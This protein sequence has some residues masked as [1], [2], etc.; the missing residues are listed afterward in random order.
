MKLSR[1]KHKLHRLRQKSRQ[2]VF[3][4]AAQTPYHLTNILMRPFRKSSKHD[5]LT[6]VQNQSIEK[7]RELKNPKVL[8]IGSRVVSRI[9]RR[10]MF[11][12]A[13]TYVGFDVL[14]GEN[15]DVVGDT[16]QLSDYFPE[17]EFDIIYSISVFEHLMF[18]WKAA[19]EINKVLK[20][21]GYVLTSTHP[22]WPEHEMP[23][24]FW[25][26]PQNSFTSLFNNKTGFEI[27]QVIE[28]RAMRAFPLFTDKP[29]RRIYRNKLNG[30]VFCLAR[31][32]A[33]Y[34]REKFK[35]DMKVEDVVDT[36]YPA[37]KD[38]P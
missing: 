29:M 5:Q 11:P 32:V 9:N 14:E 4:F 24:D 36:M 25:R 33:D 17:N 1:I 28:G 2:D 34:D 3:D 22:A 15:V 13:A 37:L 30:S 7:L 18:P 38:A 6:V 27:E 26:F 20:V 10:D 16:H 35:W 23:W 8:E 31:K 12:N 19:L 21:G